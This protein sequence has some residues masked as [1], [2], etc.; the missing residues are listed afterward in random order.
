M[1]DDD[2]PPPSPDHDDDICCDQSDDGNNK[3]DD[4][5]SADLN[6]EDRKNRRKK[7]TRTV[8]SRSQVFQLESTFDMTGD[9]GGESS[10]FISLSLATF[11]SGLRDLLNGN[12]G[13][14]FS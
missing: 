12:C 11:I 8:F 6:D 5:F 14:S 3:N 2:S 7:K 4:S 13:I 9:G 1:K 10:S